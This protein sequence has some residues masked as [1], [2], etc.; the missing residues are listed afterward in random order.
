MTP[1]LAIPTDNIYKF[2]CLFGLALIIVA[3]FS[4]VST[5]TATLDRKVKYA[6]ILI[7]LESKEPRTKIENHVLEL[8]TKLLEVTKAN[9]KNIYFA[10]GLILGIGM[11]LSYYG[12]ANWYKK[13]QLRD[14]RLVQLQLQKLEIEV[15]KL[16]LEIESAKLLMSKQSLLAMYQETG[17]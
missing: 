13:V 17:I 6:E 14:D 1:S 4:L 16:S 11:L 3:V 15:E 8:N 9:E 7:A 5:Y 10:I 2:S 12:A